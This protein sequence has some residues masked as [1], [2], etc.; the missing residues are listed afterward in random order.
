MP[1]TIFLC[2]TLLKNGKFSVYNRKRE[3]MQKD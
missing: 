2:K 3:N 1:E